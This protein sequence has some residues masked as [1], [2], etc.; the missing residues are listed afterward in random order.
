MKKT[1]L[2]LTVTSLF[3]G[4]ALAATA[5]SY[6]YNVHDIER[7]INENIETYEIEKRLNDNVVI[8]TDLTNGEKI[9]VER[10]KSGKYHVTDVNGNESS[11]I[12]VDELGNVVKIDG[13]DASIIDDNKIT[14]ISD[15]T[16]MDTYKKVENLVEHMKDTE[17]ANVKLTDGQGNQVAKIDKTNVDQYVEE[18]NK[19]SDEDKAQALRDI[20]SA[21]E[22]GQIR[23]EYDP[24]VLPD[25]IHAEA[26]NDLY[27]QGG[28]AY[29]DAQTYATQVDQT[30][31]NHEGRISGLEKSMQEMG[32]KMLVLEDRMDGVV[33]SSHAITNA[34]PVLNSAG[35]FG[36][37]VGVG[38]AGS[39]QAIAIGSAYQFNENWSGSLSVNYETKGKVSKDQ[40]SAGVGAQY[41]F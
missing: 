35:Q 10:T 16:E 5:P 6:E 26:I 24:K 31:A 7:A 41:I 22:N 19:M 33:A 36:M 13:K 29:S 21:A 9:A 2:A 40:V 28:K 39:K 17:G 20:K 38:A 25:D 37:G 1:I 14:V 32:N 18:F 34:R 23:E 11:L 8:V 4:A 15:G 27:N 3:S 30:L 12:E